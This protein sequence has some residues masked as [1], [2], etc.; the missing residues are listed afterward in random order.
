MAKKRQERKARQRGRR[1][2]DP[3]KTPPKTA[4][5]VPLEEWEVAPIDDVAEWIKYRAV[6]PEDAGD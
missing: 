5:K 3:P 4:P 6:G 2:A 1:A